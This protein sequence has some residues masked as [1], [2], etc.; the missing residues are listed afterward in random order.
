MKFT[1][2]AI[3]TLRAPGKARSY[4]FGPL[5]NPPAAFRLARR[6]SCQI[7][8]MGQ[9]RA[10]AGEIATIRQQM[11]ADI[12]AAREQMKKSFQQPWYQVVDN[13]E[14]FQISLD[15][16]GV[17]ASDIKVDLEEDGKVLS[18]NGHRSI[19]REGDMYSSSFSR[20]FYLDPSLDTNNLTANLQNGVLT[21]TAPKDLK[22][23]EEA[24]KSIPVT[25]MAS[26]EETN[27][28]TIQKS[29]ES[30][31]TIP[32]NISNEK[33]EGEAGQDTINLDKKD[34]EKIEK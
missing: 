18:L 31:D 6:S 13:G 24:T 12:A 33:E 10:I 17:K 3:A 11:R 29:A 19:S 30:H 27:S 34:K 16:P 15:V 5:F 2:S 14:Q 25:E 9:P 26:E 8:D 20:R 21:V 32:N 4:S 23:I 28:T 7:N 1:T 22:K